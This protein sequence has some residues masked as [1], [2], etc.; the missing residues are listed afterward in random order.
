MLAT[1]QVTNTSPSGP[2]SLP[3]ELAAANA[4][5]ANDDTITFAIPAT[6][7]GYVPGTGSWTILEAMPLTIAKPPSGGVQHTVFI[8]G[9]TQ[10]SQPGAATTHP[11]I[12][13]APSPGLEANGI[14]LNSGGNTIRALVISGFPSDGI[15]INPTSDNNSIVGVY[16]GTD[17]TGTSAVANQAAGIRVAGNSNKL[18]GDVIS[19]NRAEGIFVTGAGNQVL[20]SFIGTNA[21][22]A[23]AIGNGLSGI[24]LQGSPNN[25]LSGDVISGNGVKAGVGGDG[26]TLSGAN[27][28]GNLISSNKIGTNAA[29][30]AAVANLGDGIFLTGPGNM[31][32][33][34]NLISGNEFQGL[35]ISTSTAAENQV[36]GNIIGLDATGMIRIPNQS[37]LT[38]SDAPDNLVDS[39]IISGNRNK[40]VTV[41]A[42]GVTSPPVTS[43]RILGNLIGVGAD[44]TTALGNG[45]IGIQISSSSNTISSAPEGLGNV[46]AYNGQ[47]GV[48]GNGGV[49]VLSGTGNSILFNTIFSNAEVGID[50]GGDGPTPNDSKGHTGP[51]NYQN[52]P[53]ITSVTSAGGTT[54]V[55]GTL[56]ST[57]ST[58]FE[59]QFFSNDVPGPLSYGEGQ[60]FLGEQTI[61][62]DPNGHASFTVTLPTAV[63]ATQFVTAT[64]TDPNGNTSEFSQELADLS[65]T[66]D[67]PPTTPKVG[68]DFAFTI[69]VANAG[70][71]PAYNPVVMDRLPQGLTFVSATGGV[72]PDV[73]GNL[74]FPLA[75]I[76]AEGSTVL[77][78]ILR[79]TAI[80]TY[81]NNVAVSSIITDPV[82][83]NNS[84]TTSLQITNVASADL[85]VSGVASPDPVDLGDNLT[86]TLTV[87]NNGPDSISGVN[88]TDTLPAATSLVS[89]SIPPI[90]SG[91]LAFDLGTIAAGAN[92][93]VSIVV[94]TS[95]IGP[96]TNTATVSGPTGAFDP[97]LSNNTATQT[98]EVG[99]FVV[100]TTAD[101]INGFPAP[102]SLRAA[103]LASNRHPGRDTITFKIVPQEATYDIKLDA[104]LPP[105]TDPVVI[106]ATTQPGYHGA[107]IVLVDGSA[108]QGS[109]LRFNR[110]NSI[111][112]G[113]AVGGFPDAG[114][115]LQSGDGDLIESCYLGIDPPGSRPIGNGIG[116]L[117]TAGSGIT[118]G[119]TT[120]GA[121][122]TISGNRTAGILLESSAAGNA[123][124]AGNQ[125]GTDATGASAITQSGETSPLKALQNVG[126]LIDGS[127]GN[128][129]GGTTPQARNLISGNYVGVDI[130]QVAAQSAPNRVLGNFIGTDATGLKPLGNIVGVYI[131]RASGNQVGG[132]GPEDANVISANLQAG[133]EI[134]GPAA[135]SNALEGNTIG[136]AADG[137]G[138]FLTGGGLL[139]QNDGVYLEDASGNS[140]GGPGAGAGNVISGNQQAGVFILSRSSVSQGNLVQA[141]DIGAGPGGSA[142]PGNMG[143]GVVL[144]NA[145]NNQVVVAGQAP[146]VFGPSGIANIRNYVGPLPAS[147]VLAQA[148]RVGRHSKARAAS[149]AR[150]H[151]AGPAHHLSKLMARTRALQNA[152]RHQA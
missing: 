12:V 8:D 82:P 152:K 51:N 52:F 37:G 34:G 136:L 123:L 101:L 103:I 59:V 117:A 70:P 89:T 71:F 55:V 69:I 138:V 98:T 67:V 42:A 134:L 62:T 96:V 111:V 107:P 129:V 102:G 148:T 25:T 77:S 16:A 13:L 135:S 28:H 130:A 45:Q 68:Q 46:I 32:G 144:Y 125:I 29:G 99:G 81:S 94:A 115:L 108:V 57:P 80:G 48:I 92:E 127:S 97:N 47:A 151:P 84:D 5:V 73:N 61:A 26:I 126:I 39:N 10:Q 128:T 43:A 87:T 91:P 106:D 23:S 65:V 2:G 58:N 100:T 18:T 50:L 145:T 120:Q 30:S 124:I 53:V 142:G 6:D 74:T 90:S 79:A 140:I 109:G 4:D 88:L 114:I 17:P 76:P 86:Y 11:A 38:I 83:D 75:T 40:G 133:V 49:V 9:T 78:V 110:G 54:T 36:F 72:T 31:I 35:E 149:H 21:A 104:P 141:N 150:A 113:L 41:T 118:I 3:F 15:L 63:S 85:A 60:T 147:Q 112:L 19:G 56:N 105:V 116:L 146:N 137:K 132:T 33:S 131:L 22:G 20:N 24:T 44:G 14:A 119:G 139:L 27:S 95:Q 1:F 64:A 121:G 143:Y 66:Q 122:N 7:P 93:V